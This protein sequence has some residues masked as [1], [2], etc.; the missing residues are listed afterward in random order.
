M[1]IYNFLFRIKVIGKSRDVNTL[2]NRSIR[3][4]VSEI[5]R[6]SAGSRLTPLFVVGS[7]EDHEKCSPDVYSVLL[8]K[9]YISE[10]NDISRKALLVWILK[11]K[12]VFIDDNSLDS[13]IRKL[14]GFHFADLNTLIAVAVK[15]LL[16]FLNVISLI[17]F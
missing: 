12:N 13:I 17:I 3:F 8:H 10:L 16:K 9:T 4:F 11:E 7:C 5:T 2:D 1:Y 6:I 14:N 15:Y